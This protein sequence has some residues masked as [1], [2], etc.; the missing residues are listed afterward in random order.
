MKWVQLQNDAI[1]ANSEA[2]GL[3]VRS[4]VCFLIIIC[5]RSVGLV[6]RFD[7]RSYLGAPDSGSAEGGHPDRF[8]P[9]CSDFPVFFRFVPIC[10]PCFR[11]YAD[12]FRFAP[13]SS[14]ICSVLFSEQVREPPFCRP[15]LQIPDYL[16]LSLSFRV[17][18]WNL[19]CGPNLEM[20][21]LVSPKK[22]ASEPHCSF[23]ST[24]LEPNFRDY[25][26]GGLPVELG[27]KV[28]LVNT[29]QCLT[30]ESLL[31]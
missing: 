6:S 7:S 20:A 28:K 12:L 14:L 16:R 22:Q 18:V 2:V 27:F 25:C 31:F 4:Q 17:C 10:A 11:E 1:R 8:V 9:I 19:C 5:R 3:G 29:F 30:L 23:R 26:L 13:N 15:L 21:C 24:G